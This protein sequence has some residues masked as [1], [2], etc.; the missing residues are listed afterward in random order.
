M[1]N[2]DFKIDTQILK[3]KVGLSA[4]YSMLDDQH[5][6][7]FFG[8]D[9][10][11]LLNG[12]REYLDNSWKVPTQSC[13]KRLLAL[14]DY[15]PMVEV[16]NSTKYSGDRSSEVGNT[17]RFYKPAL[18]W[19]ITKYTSH[20]RNAYYVHYIGKKTALEHLDCAYEMTKDHFE[21]WEDYGRSFMIYKCIWDNDNIEFE[22]EKLF[23]EP[24]ANYNA[25]EIT[26]MYN[27]LYSRPGLIIDSEY[28]EI[29]NNLLND[30][31]SIWNQVPWDI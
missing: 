14:K 10:D 4:I 7:T 5:D 28:V 2:K 3:R 26:H 16:L 9:D 6:R 1:K 19:D 23:K 29:L 25:E 30:R 13:T 22:L 12:L 31:T 17:K 21:S 18:A 15:K 24:E 11:R 20:I 27:Y 8:E